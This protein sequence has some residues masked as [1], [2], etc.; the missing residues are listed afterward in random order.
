MK[1]FRRS[2]SIHPTELDQ[3]LAS[4]ATI[5]DVRSD[6]E[7]QAG[8]LPTARHIPLDELPSRLDEIRPDQLAVLVCRSG[9][10][11]AMATAAL[12]RRGLEVANLTGG[13][14]ACSRHGIALV[15]DDGAPGG[16]A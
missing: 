7:W 3:A 1:L 12:A 8:H 9:S 15:R 10:R 2:T 14:A 4:G 11:S 5:I 13:L 6:E 16:V